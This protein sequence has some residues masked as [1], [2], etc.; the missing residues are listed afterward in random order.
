MAQQNV[1]CPDGLP[2]DSS[3]LYSGSFAKN[4]VQPVTQFNSNGSFRWE[5]LDSYSRL[6]QRD[7]CLR[8]HAGTCGPTYCNFEE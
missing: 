2:S 3:R 7:D 5:A 8:A 6:T 4:E 1:H